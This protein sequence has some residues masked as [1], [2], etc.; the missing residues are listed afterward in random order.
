MVLAAKGLP[1]AES[2]RL[3]DLVVFVLFA[4]LVAV[5]EICLSDK[6]VVSDKLDVFALSRLSSVSTLLDEL[7]PLI[8]LAGLTEL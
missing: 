5:A 6:S 7:V 2:A 4:G 1:S 3:W 8:W